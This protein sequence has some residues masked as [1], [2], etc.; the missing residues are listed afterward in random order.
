MRNF[1]RHPRLLALLVGLA[2]VGG[3]ACR[4][5]M[6]DQAKIEPLE[7]S[8]FFAD[9]RASRPIP[10]GTVAR[11]HLKADRALATGMGDGGFVQNYPVAVD[12]DLVRWG[13][14]RYDIYCSPCHDRAGDGLGM[15]VQRGYTQPT[16][17]HD[18][19]LRKA[20]PGYFFNAMTNGFGVMPSYAAQVPV[21]DRWAIV[22]YIKAL[23]LSRGAR[24]DELERTDQ[25]ALEG[26][27]A[28]DG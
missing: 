3:S 16:S 13:R 28:A 19:R 27:E 11:G 17:F 21:R 25:N 5:D 10:M 1:T 26:L 9:G 6:H 18:E 12:A 23:Q 2:L 8:S 7:A 24:F 14:T 15:I 4:Q 20:P 22:A